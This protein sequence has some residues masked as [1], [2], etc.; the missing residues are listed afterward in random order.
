MLVTKKYH[1]TQI[2]ALEQRFKE[3]LDFLKETHREHISSLES[4]ISDLEKLVFPTNNSKNISKDAAE[5]DSVI[6]VSEKPSDMSEEERTRLLEGSR[7]FDM[8][9]SGNYDEDLL[10]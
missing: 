9:L 3:Q 4:H 7:E 5:F 8:I 1:L 10:Q 6:S 2:N